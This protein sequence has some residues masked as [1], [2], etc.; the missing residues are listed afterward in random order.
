MKVSELGFDKKEAQK[1]PFVHFRCSSSQRQRNR[2]ST[3]AI[4]HLSKFDNP[5][6]YSR[7]AEASANAKTRGTIGR[8]EETDAIS[9]P[10]V[11][12]SGRYESVQIER[13]QRIDEDKERHVR[14]DPKA[15]RLRVY[16]QSKAKRRFERSQMVEQR[17]G[18]R[19]DEQCGHQAPESHSPTS[20]CRVDRVPW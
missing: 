9:D 13:V 16:E 1:T 7:A 19:E 12:K 2:G 17:V 15:Y 4:R 11:A 10:K 14:L 6:W 5:S 8:S 18:Q 3:V 20:A